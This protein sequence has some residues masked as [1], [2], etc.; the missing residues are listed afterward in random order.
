M[1][2][3]STDPR[4]NGASSPIQLKHTDKETGEVRTIEYRMR[5]LSDVDMTE[6]DEWVRSTYIANARKSLGADCTQTEREETLS[7]AMTQAVGMSFLSGIGARMMGT[8]DGVARLV[9]QSI[10]AEH[11]DVTVEMVKGYMFDKANIAEG[12]RK[13]KELNLGRNKAASMGK[14]PGVGKGKQQ[15]KRNKGGKGKGKGK[16]RDR[17]GR[18]ST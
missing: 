13:W 4:L 15:R 16:G 5:P 2:T 18:R 14:S 3:S 10:K 6:L 8:V 12:N 7:L 9:W 1:T 11:P 17:R